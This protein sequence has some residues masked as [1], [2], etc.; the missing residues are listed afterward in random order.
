M[1]TKFIGQNKLMLLLNIQGIKKNVNLCLMK[2]VDCFY[3]SIWKEV[4][5]CRYGNI[6]WKIIERFQEVQVI[7]KYWIDD[8]QCAVI[9]SW[10]Y[11]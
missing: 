10:G 2:E 5:F 8:N 1:L 11:F 6:T 3:T 7:L 4:M 9:I